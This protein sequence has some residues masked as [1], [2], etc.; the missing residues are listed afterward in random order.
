VKYRTQKILVT[1]LTAV[2]TGALGRLFADTFTKEAPSPEQRT[3]AD[4]TKEAVSHAVASVIAVVV[5]SAI[6]RWI[7][8]RSQA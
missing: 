6:V 7:A 4:D 1:G 5:A 8:S 2:I 3:L